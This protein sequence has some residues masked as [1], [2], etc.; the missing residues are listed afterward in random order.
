[1]YIVPLTSAP[2]QTFTATIP[3]DEKKVKLFFF[4]RYNTEQKCWE[5][6]L[7]DENKKPLIHSVPLICG[8]NILEQH[9]YLNIGSAYIVKL[10]INISDDRPNE[11]NLGEKFIL[12]WGDTE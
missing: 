1:M 2:N 11:Y 8:L 3:I 12:V 4:L 9:S 5:M 10:D 6:D 7:E